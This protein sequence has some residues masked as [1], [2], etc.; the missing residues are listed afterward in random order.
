MWLNEAQDASFLPRWQKSGWNFSAKKNCEHTHKHTLLLAHTHTHTH[1]ADFFQKNSI[2]CAGHTVL[3]YKMCAASLVLNNTDFTFMILN[4]SPVTS[5]YF[6]QA[7][8]FING[9]HN[10]HTAPTILLQCLWLWFVKDTNSNIWGA[11]LLNGC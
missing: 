3:L 2:L 9:T 7:I 8:S 11:H 1:N 5:F 6:V 4:I 10:V